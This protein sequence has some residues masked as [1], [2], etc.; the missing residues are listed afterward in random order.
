M[1]RR[2]NRLAG[3]AIA[4]LVGGSLI[5]IGVQPA[6]ASTDLTLS[7]IITTTSGVQVSTFHSGASTV[8]VSG[9]L[10][11]T[12]VLHATPNSASVSFA[13]AAVRNKVAPAPITLKQ[14]GEQAISAAVAVGM[15]RAEAIRLLAPQLPYVATLLPGVHPDSGSGTA[16]KTVVSISAYCASYNIGYA[17]GYACMTPTLARADNVGNWVVAERQAAQG[18]VTGLIRYLTQV[19][20]YTVHPTKNTI[21]DW[22]PAFARPDAGVGCNS[23]TVALTFPGFASY[24]QTRQICRGKLVPVI[25]Q[26]D[27]YGRWI[28]GGQW[29][30]NQWAAQDVYFTESDLLIN[31]PSNASYYGTYVVFNMSWNN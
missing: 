18:Q 28:E 22:S 26:Q 8:R 16:T 1:Q 21:M 13:P 24:S 29:V 2:T 20:V 9:A 19:Q 7:S 31:S 17:I 4:A 10:A 12:P 3:L 15:T 25:P 27:A 23:Q 30:G 14:Q 11:G 6:Q 5:A